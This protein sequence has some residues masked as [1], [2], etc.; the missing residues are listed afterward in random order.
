MRVGQLIA[1][2]YRLDERIGAGGMGVVWRATDQE[3]HR[4]V[5]LKRANAPD[6]TDRARKRAD[7]E[8]RTIANL[9]HP[10]IVTLLD[11]V[12]DDEDMRWLVM[13]YVPSRSLAEIL[14]ERRRLP[15][16]DV[17]R[18]GTQIASALQ[19]VHAKDVVH[20]DV[21]PGNILVGD[22]GVA[23]LT[24]FG[25]SRPLWNDTTATDSGWI[26]GTPAYLAPEVA[27]GKEPT[28]AADV[29]SLGA[30]LYAAVEGTPP[31]G[32][33]DNPLQAVHRAASGE[34]PPPRRAGALAPALTALLDRDPANRPNAAAARRLLREVAG[35]ESGDTGDDLLDAAPLSRRRPRRRAV[36]AT[37]AAVVAVAVGVSMLVVLPNRL[38]REPTKA[39]GERPT[40][41]VATM[42]DPHTADPCGLLDVGSLSEFGDPVLERAYGNFD[43]CDVILPAEGDGEDIDVQILLDTPSDE[44]P[45]GPGERVG[46]FTVFR[47]PE[48]DNSCDRSIVL[49]D[50]SRVHVIVRQYDKTSTELC[51]IADSATGTALDVLDGQGMPRKP[52]PEDAS[53]ASL[54]ACGL[55]DDDALS[56][57]PGVDADDPDVGFGHW[58]C[59]WYST[60]SNLQLQLR[61]DQ[62]PPLSADDGVVKQ[63][64]G[65]TGY[66]TPEGDGDNT[67]LARLVY[68]DRTGAD[69]EKVQ[70]HVYLVMRGDR[71]GAD[72]CDLATSLIRSAAGALPPPR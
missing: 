70:E 11:A 40:T 62:S 45:E 19:A 66:I 60:T 34:V 30:T 58:E 46:G 44:P 64:A 17:A 38:A 20:R 56:V 27:G 51:A 24:D 3:L 23:K 15:P 28:A 7:R 6:A 43:R 29:F 57:I 49:G 42:G 10:H 61:Y 72:L 26:G 47:A 59:R 18:I 5:S 65:R 39:S 67:C 21:K 13:E 63:F 36:I 48:D 54:D 53:L 32:E 25:I 71:P 35:G 2:R 12:T 22:D 33:V 4:T 31:F 1:G 16:E 55:L 69:G 8:A 9:N 41:Q 68:R 50:G 52:A 37:A 14:Q